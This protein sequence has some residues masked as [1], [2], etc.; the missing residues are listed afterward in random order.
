VL[1]HFVES[2]KLIFPVPQFNSY[3]IPLL[4]LS[5]PNKKS[6]LFDFAKEKRERK[7]SRCFLAR[8]RIDLTFVIELFA[9]LYCAILQHVLSNNSADTSTVPLNMSSS[10]MSSGPNL[11]GSTGAMPFAVAASSSFFCRLES[12]S[13][14]VLAYKLSNDSTILF[15]FN[16]VSLSHEMEPSLS[17]QYSGMLLTLFSFHARFFYVYLFHH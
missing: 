9:V 7:I 16:N 12:N 6:F 5:Q 17:V 15:L 4:A 11:S 10:G 13:T 8:K 3:F 14:L 1:V 2:Y